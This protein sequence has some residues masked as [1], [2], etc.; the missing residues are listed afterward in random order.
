MSKE[1]LENI[2]DLKKLLL[3]E[4]DGYEVYNNLMGLLGVEQSV[5]EE[6]YLSKINLEYIS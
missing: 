1:N 5:I 6:G 2:E 3:S 4:D